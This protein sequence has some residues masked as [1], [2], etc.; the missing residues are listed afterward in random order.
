MKVCSKS[1]INIAAACLCTMQG[2][3]IGAE[4]NTAT[5]A[6]FLMQQMAWRGDLEARTLDAVGSLRATVAH[7]AEPWSL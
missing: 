6:P 1:M 3:A 5:R 2:H 7:C 4:S